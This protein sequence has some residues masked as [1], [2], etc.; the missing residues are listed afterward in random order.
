MEISCIKPNLYL[1]AGI[2]AKRKTEEFKKLNI[3]VV[4]NCCNEIV[5]EPNDIFIVEN[6]P[7]N[8]GYDATIYPWLDEI[9][10]KIKSYLDQNKRVYVHC[11]QGRSRSPAII[12]YYLMKYENMTYSDAFMFVKPI[13]PVLSLNLNFVVELMAI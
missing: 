9:V 1:G 13:R 10:D 6:F 8:D 7:I 3:D 2:H 4:I 11:V 12:I 5:H